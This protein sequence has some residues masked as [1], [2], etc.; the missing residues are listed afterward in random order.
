MPS[1]EC[2]KWLQ[3]AFHMPARGTRVMV[4]LSC[5]RSSISPLGAEPAT[6]RELANSAQ[7]DN[8]G[9][10]ATLL[11]A[12]GGVIRGLWIGYVPGDETAVRQAI[13]KALAELKKQS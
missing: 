1:V 3:C 13:E 6:I 5:G 7:I 12:P 11:L 9:F 2:R 10:P 8:F 4:L